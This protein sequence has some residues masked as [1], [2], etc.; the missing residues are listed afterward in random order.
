MSELF[1]LCQ[2]MLSYAAILFRQL[3]LHFFQFPRAYALE[4]KIECD[5]KQSNVVGKCKK[6]LN[7]KLF[8]QFS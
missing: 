4:D 8:F 3:N 5:T 7:Q 6:I 2:L 1:D